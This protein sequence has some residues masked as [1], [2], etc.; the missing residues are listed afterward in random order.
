[1][2]RQER[3]ESG[4]YREKVSLDEVRQFFRRS[5][6]RTAA[7]I[8]D[9]LDISSRAVL[10]KLNRMHDNQEIKRK[11]VGARAVVW[12][13]ELNPPTAAEVLAEMTGRPVEDFESPDD[14]Y[15]MPALE[16]LEWERVEED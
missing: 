4:R 11:K 7:E 14:A 16:D 12:Y 6:P 1:M 15:P 10:N 8:A 9:E 2:S 3:D 5:E 13:R